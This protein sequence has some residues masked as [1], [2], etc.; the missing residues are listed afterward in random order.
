MDKDAGKKRA[1]C[2]AAKYVERGMTLGL[3]TG[4][5]ARYFVDALAPKA[6]EGWGL[7]GVPTSEETRRQAEAIG[8]EI[9]VPDETTII[10]L[11]VDGTDEADPALNLIKG[12]GGALLREKIVANAA[13]QFIVIADKSKRVAA[14]GAYPLPV[15]IEPFGWALAVRNIRA[16]LSDAGFDGAAMEL[17]APQ[18]E[19]FKSDGGHLIL[20]CALGR[21]E[22]PANLDIMLKAIPGVIETGL[23]CGMADMIIYG[24]ADGVS[25]DEADGRA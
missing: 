16:A 14:L 7:S 25:I 6:A 18:G 17:R 11:A 12:G 5:T 3:G 23:F 9:I 20:D 10:D 22:D 15:E 2:E 1:G 13:R 4:S 8:I 24:D 21:I 19:I